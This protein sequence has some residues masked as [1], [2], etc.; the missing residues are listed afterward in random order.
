MTH[1]LLKLLNTTRDKID[2]GSL[3]SQLVTHLLYFLILSPPPHRP[4]PPPHFVCGSNLLGPSFY[5]VQ[6]SPP[7]HRP[8][9]PPHF[10]CGSNLLGP[11]FYIVQKVV[12]CQF[13]DVT[14]QQQEDSCT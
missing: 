14:A 11:S 4:H 9:S 1:S 12:S 10:V 6:K 13:P 2:S 7:P 8:H 5:I 3:D